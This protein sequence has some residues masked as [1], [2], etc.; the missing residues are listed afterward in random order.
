MV[1]M[2]NRFPWKLMKVGSSSTSYN[3]RVDDDFEGVV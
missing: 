3:K 1:M 2:G